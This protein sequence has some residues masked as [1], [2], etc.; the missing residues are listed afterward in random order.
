VG[1]NGRTVYPKRHRGAT[2]GDQQS[3]GSTNPAG[4]GGAGLECAAYLPESSGLDWLEELREQHIEKLRLFSTA[5]YAAAD[6]EELQEQDEATWR[7]SVRDALAAGREAPSRA[8]PYVAEAAR[9][10]GEEDVLTA[11][12]ELSR[13]SVEALTEIRKPERRREL[14]AA[15][16]P[17]SQAL[18]DALI[19]GPRGS[20]EAARARLRER[21]DSLGD[22]GGIED[23]SEPETQAER[24]KTLRA[25]F[26]ASPGGLVM[27]TILRRSRAFRLI[28]FHPARLFRSPSRRPAESSR[29]RGEDLSRAP[30]LNEAEGRV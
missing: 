24:Q 15:D 9:L 13:V 26:R 29:R 4:G 27:R 10:A 6:V 12:T 8:D 1:E 30:T 16:I 18:R 7:H 3:K 28:A 2:N 17:I 11:R 23:M 19:G 5:V 14:V 22:E 20:I 25:F 21:L